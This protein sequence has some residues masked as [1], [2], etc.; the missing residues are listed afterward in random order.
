MGNWTQRHA[1]PA[2]ALALSMLLAAPA[3]AREPPCNAAAMR[4]GDAAIMSLTANPSAVA[5]AVASHLPW[6]VPAEAVP[7]TNERRLVQADYVIDYDA[8]LHVPIWTAERVVA[9]RLDASVVRTDCFRID[10]RLD[11]ITSSV[12]KDYKS[13]GYDRGHLAPFANQRYSIV[14][15]NNS[16]ILTNMAPQLSDFNSGIWG[17][18]EDKARDWAGSHPDLYIL[19]GSVF[20]RDGDGRRDPD[21]A[22][23]NMTT[24]G[25]KRVAIPTHFFKIVAFRGAGGQIETISF[26]LPHNKTRPKGAA[27][28]AYLT[29]HITDIATIERLTGLDFFPTAPSIHESRTL[30]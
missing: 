6:G 3:G 15:G 24:N 4:A 1:L 18:L 29:A 23:V 28:P 26:V 25:G 16:F 14:A 8:D 30:W 21:S 5:A 10:P 12:L 13:S 11:P 9:A 27:I 17:K 19:S 2:L 7:T 22:A 20:D